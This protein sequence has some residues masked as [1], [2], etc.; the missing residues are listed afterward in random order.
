MESYDE[1]AIVQNA[2]AGRLVRALEELPDTAFR[3]V[4]EIGCCTGVLTEMLCRER[5]V[6]TLFLNDLVP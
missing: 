3:R 5:Q 4:L 1:A 6:R 2:L